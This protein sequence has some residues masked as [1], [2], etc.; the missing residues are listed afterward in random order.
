[1]RETS[2]SREY[3]YFNGNASDPNVGAVIR[4]NFISLLKSPFFGSVFCRDDHKQC[5]EDGV[6]V[7]AGKLSTT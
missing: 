5:K 1:M 2:A 4:T 6:M 7:V 3:Y